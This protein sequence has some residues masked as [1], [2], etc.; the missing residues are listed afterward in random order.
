LTAHTPNDSNPYWTSCS[1]SREQGG[2]GKMECRDWW[3]YSKNVRYLRNY[4]ATAEGT[5]AGQY[6]RTMLYENPISFSHQTPSCCL[7]SF[8]NIRKLVVVL[9]I[10]VICLL[11]SSTTIQIATSVSYLLV[12]S[13]FPST[14]TEVIGVSTHYEALRTQNS[15]SLIESLQ[16]FTLHS[17]EIPYQVINVHSLDELVRERFRSS[18]LD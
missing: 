14:L 2:G 17:K 7:L 11:Y 15:R 1:T 4:P 8:L 16:R 10:A 6:T 3:G 9:V 13:W 5:R 18:S 12:A